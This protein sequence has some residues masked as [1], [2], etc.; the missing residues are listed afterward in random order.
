MNIIEIFRPGKFK[1]MNGKEIEFSASMLQDIAANYNTSVYQAPLVI[2]HPKVEDP[3]YGWVKNL[4]F[5]DG[6]LKAEPESVVEEFAG[7]VSAGLYKNVSAS[8][9]APDHPANP[10]PGKYYLKHVGFLGAT[11]PAVSGLKAVSFA[12]G[13]EQE[14]CFEFSDNTKTAE[15][16]AK[17]QELLKKEKALAA[18][19]TELK[20][21]EFSSFICDL[22]KKGQILPALE[23]GLVEFMMALDSQNTLE[24]AGVKQN[25]LDFFKSFL[26]KQPKLVNF[27]EFAPDSNATNTELT[28]NQLAEKARKLK[29]RLETE[30]MVI[31]YADS[32]TRA[33]KGEE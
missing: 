27:G 25:Q 21:A 14:I 30:G 8:F 7:I 22:K 18:R 11:P 20:K 9:F 12:S 6:K 26:S 31:S 23:S 3:A 10:A 13:D 32:V 5:A 17:E 33:S 2:G 15:F 28:P 4:S 24:F 19:E 16:A 1:A 29:N